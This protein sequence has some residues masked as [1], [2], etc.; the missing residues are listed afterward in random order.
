MWYVET[1]TVPKEPPDTDVSSDVSVSFPR[2][3]ARLEKIKIRAVS[4]ARF[5]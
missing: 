5:Q 2:H 4:M 1:M 3:P